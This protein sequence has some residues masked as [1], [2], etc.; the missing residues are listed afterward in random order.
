MHVGTSTFQGVPIKPQGMMNWHP[1]ATIWHPLKGPGRYRYTNQMDGAIGIWKT[2]QPFHIHTFNSFNTQHHQVT[3]KIEQKRYDWVPI[4]CWYRWW[5]RL[6][7]CL[8]SHISTH[9]RHA[10]HGQLWWC[11]EPFQPSSLM[12]P[13]SSYKAFPQAPWFTLPKINMEPKNDGF[14]KTPPIPY[15]TRSHF[16]VPC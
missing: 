14:Q 15:S 4:L 12:S 9:C 5:W 1:L 13:T 11:F 10:K 6:M 16:Q 3:P 2:K 7:V 8:T